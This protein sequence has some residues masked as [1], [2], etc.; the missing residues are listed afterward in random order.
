MITNLDLSMRRI[1]HGKT[2]GNKYKRL[3]EDKFI[4]LIKS[5]KENNNIFIYQLYCLV[6]N[7]FTHFRGEGK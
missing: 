6:L 5:K 4:F 2:L 7:H 3:I 1:K